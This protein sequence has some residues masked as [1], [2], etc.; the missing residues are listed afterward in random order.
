[1]KKW[2]WVLLW[3]SGVAAHPLRDGKLLVTYT[4]Y[5]GQTAILMLD[6]QGEFHMVRSSRGEELLDPSWAPDGGIFYVAATGES[7]R[8]C[9]INASGEDERVVEEFAGGRASGPSPSPDGQHLLLTV[10]GKDGLPQLWLADGQ[11]SGA[12]A[13]GPKGAGDPAWSGD[14]QQF[15]AVL[16]ENQLV[17]YDLEGR[18]VRSLHS[19]QEKLRT[20]AWSSDG[21]QLVVSRAYHL[22]DLE[23]RELTAGDATEANPTFDDQGRILFNR[24]SARELS[25]WSCEPDGKNPKLVVE[26]AG[27]QGA[28]RLLWLSLRRIPT[29]DH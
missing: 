29:A 14:S 23:G 2:L 3:A 18:A 7:S 26:Y 15:V 24:V 21:R 16:G 12:H 6:R 17:V 5:S 25:V 19:G 8:L 1:M 22:V 10:V 20:P 9:W 28:A 27:I 4:S 13:L 11:G